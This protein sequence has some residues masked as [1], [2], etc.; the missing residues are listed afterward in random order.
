MLHAAVLRSPHAARPDRDA[1][2]PR[3][4]APCPACT[5]SSP[6]CRRR[7]CATRCPTSAPTRPGTPG[8]AWP[9]TRCATWAR[10]SRSPS[11]TAAYLAEDALELIEVEYEPL[12]AVVD[13]EQAL[14]GGAPLVH[15]ALE[16][17]CAYERTFDF[18][19]G[20]ARLRRGRRRRHRPPPLAPLGR[21]AAGD[22]RGHRQLRP[23]HRQL[24]HRHQHAELHQLPVHGR[25]HAQGARPTSSTSGRCRPAAASAPSCSPPSR[26]SSPPCARGKPGK[27]VAYLEDRT[28]N[29]ANCDHHGSDR[30]YDVELAMM[31]DGTMR[32]I[33]I[34]VVD[35]YGAYIQFGVG[36][37]RQ[38][39]GPGHRPVHDPQRAVPGA[40][41]A[42]QQ[43]PA[44]RLPGLRLRGEQ[45]DA[46]ADGRQGRP[47]ARP[48]PG[49][50][51]AARTSSGSSR[52]S[53][54]P[55]TSTTP[56]TTTTVLDKAL[57]LADYGHWRAEQAAAPRAEGRYLGIGV[58]SAQERSVFSAT[59][60]WFWFDE[61]G[62]P[63]TSTPESR[64][65]HGRRHRR[66][67]RHA[68]LLRVLGQQ[69]GDDGRRSSSPRSSTAT[70]H[71]VSVVY[72]GSRGGLPAHRARRLPDHR[73]AGRARSRAHRRRSRQKALRRRRRTSSRSPRTTWSGPTAASRSR[74]TP[75][76]R[77]TL[78]EIAV[79]LHLFKHSFPEEME[80]GPG[81]V[82]RSST[83]RT[84][85]CRPPTARISASSIPSWA[86]PA[87]SR[88]SRWTP[89][90]A[91][92]RSSHY[93]AVH[94]CGTLVNPRSL[95][96]H[97][98]GGTAQGIGTALYEEYVYGDDGQ[99]AHRPAYLDY[100][101]PS[102][103]EVPELRDR[104]RARRRRRTRRTGSRAAARAAG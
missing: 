84:R 95:A 22:R 18:G 73:D 64:D 90:R 102:A 52:T 39:P 77:K 65:A 100:L 57:E 33:K 78:G 58:I 11:R 83:T 30:V 55:A 54:R 31:R 98:V 12:P 45:L 49:R 14:A 40:G 37:S 70:R 50:P 59:E 66:D 24:H 34:D 79:M 97:I 32:G 46:R 7:S 26:G 71:D 13:P 36:P 16:S 75:E 80:S 88:S 74:A 101:I 85:R 67:H 104:A 81:G 23:G 93:A 94:D 5:R 2:T 20:R 1:S 10:A 62:A 89:R 4:A 8:A 35:D 69:P 61:P 76:Q 41:G 91:W 86:T 63:V 87:T 99:L 56:A 82:A 28:D 29:I 68:V 48:R 44:G 21:P 60:F 17:N 3:G 96:G 9:W 51:S 92:S 6:G 43:E 42:D 15:E 38:R 27:T 72:H 103:M 25:G 53:S 19:D 47:R